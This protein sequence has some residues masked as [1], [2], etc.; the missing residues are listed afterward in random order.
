MSS[1]SRASVPEYSITPAFSPRKVVF[2]Y[3]RGYRGVISDSGIKTLCEYIDLAIDLYQPTHLA[4]QLD[5]PGGS[6]SALDYW[7][8]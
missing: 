1:D 5:S 4:L 6:A 3:R 8:Y 7:L 2:T